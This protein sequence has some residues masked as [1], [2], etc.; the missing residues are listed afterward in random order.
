MLWKS[1]LVVGKYRDVS[2]CYD[3]IQGILTNGILKSDP[4]AS[5]G[6]NQLCIRTTFVPG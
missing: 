6:L 5:E 4:I 3:C 1:N 2:N